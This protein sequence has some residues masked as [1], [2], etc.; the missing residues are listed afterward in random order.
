MDDYGLPAEQVFVSTVYDD[1]REAAADEAAWAD[2]FAE[3]REVWTR[4]REGVLW[5]RA[6]GKEGRL[7]GGI[8]AKVVE[9]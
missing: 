6:H 4:G 7:T 2:L 5:L 1:L 3:G 8:K 9:E